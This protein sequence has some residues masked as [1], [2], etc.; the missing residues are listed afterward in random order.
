MHFVIILQLS[1]LVSQIHFQC[2][3]NINFFTNPNTIFVHRTSERKI[4]FK[5]VPS[6]YPKAAIV[7]IF[8]SLA[9]STD[10][11]YRMSM[12]SRPSM[13][14]GERMIPSMMSGQ[15]FFAR[16][17]GRIMHEFDDL[18]GNVVG[19]FDDAMY[20]PF[21]LKRTIRP[22][23]LLQANPESSSLALK[24]AKKAFD[25]TQNDKEFQIAVNIPGA[26]ASDVNLQLENDDRILRVF[27]EMNREDEGISVRSRFEKT[28]ML[29]RNID[30]SKIT[31][32]FDSGVL[33]IT[34]PKKVE[35]KENVRRINIVEHD[36]EETHEP[37]VKGE[38]QHVAAAV[39]EEKVAAVN[40]D[41][42]IDLDKEK[43]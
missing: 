7:A 38:N 27:G 28:F 2:K 32:H 18:F 13:S 6:F 42:V 12:Q 25:I 23:Y 4:Y 43:E 36:N 16:D 5:M 20:Q 34:A 37:D 3:T 35:E 41:S 24:G 1:S 10:A 9:V 15:S 17:V 11:A 29:H 40:D 39:L 31:A 30:A 33:T 21:L 19:G 14:L 22:S 26:K 8:A